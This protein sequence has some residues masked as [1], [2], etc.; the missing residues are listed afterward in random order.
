MPRVKVRE[1]HR[2]KG[3][4]SA[5]FLLVVV[6]AFGYV[7]YPDLDVIGVQIDTLRGNGRRGVRMGSIIRR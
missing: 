1:T 4:A 5:Y 6:L 7:G 3:P 2:A